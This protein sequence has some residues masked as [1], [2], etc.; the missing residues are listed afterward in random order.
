MIIFCTQSVQEI[1]SCLA[2]LGHWHSGEK[3]ILLTN[4]YSFSK[5]QFAEQL[6]SNGVFSSVIFM[7]FAFEDK[8]NRTL[9]ELEI[10]ILKK[11]DGL[12]A[13][14]MV[15]LYKSKIIYTICDLC[16]ESAIY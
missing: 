14:N 12:F 9:E 1:P 8:R 16:N 7:R 13:E 5:S 3:S 4:D 11:L 15:E 6:V 10:D 2:L